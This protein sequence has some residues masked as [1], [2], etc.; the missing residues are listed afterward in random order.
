MTLHRASPAIPLLLA[1]T[2]ASCSDYA[3]DARK[4]APVDTHGLIKLSPSSLDFGEQIPDSH[5]VRSFSILNVGDGP[6]HFDSIGVELSDAFTILGEAPLS[7]DD[8]D[9]STLVVEYEPTN[10][11]D[12][13]RIVVRSDAENAFEV[14]ELTGTGLFP[15]L[16]LE[17]SSLEMEAYEGGIAEATLLAR[18]TGAAPLN[19]KGQ[20]LQGSEAFTVS[21]EIPVTLAPGEAAP[22]AVTFTPPS[23]S[24]PHTARLWIASDDPS[25]DDVAE[26]LGTVHPLCLG[27]GEAWERGILDIRYQLSEGLVLENASPWARICIDDWYFYISEGTQDAGAGDP[28]FEP[29]DVYGYGG[30]RVVEPL[31]SLV[32]EYGGV[33]DPAWW[34]VEETQVTQ[35]AELFSFNGARVPEPLLGHMVLDRDNDAV[36]AAMRSNPV[37]AVGKRPGWVSVSEGIPFDVRIEVTNLGR[38]EGTAL[39]YETIPSGYTLSDVSPPPIEHVDT[40]DA[41]YLTFSVA[42]EAAVDTPQ[43]EPTIY[44]TASISYTLVASSAVCLGRSFLPAPL[45]EWRDAA[46]DLRFAEGSPLVLECW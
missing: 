15:Q 37:M 25:G 39:V 27:P 2:L 20:I 11:L 16:T 26:L 34:C 33:E 6:V 41:T 17:P 35:D 32:F 23:H 5:A 22:F 3:L 14:V 38:V 29:E 43:P 21:A 10:A 18:N 12:D 7:L 1:S 46:G 13:G 24:K 19:L 9:S 4:E 36:W 44:D 31:S 8:G 30:S 40:E 42:L 45:S 28:Y